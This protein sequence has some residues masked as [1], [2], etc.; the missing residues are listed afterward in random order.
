MSSGSAQA[1]ASAS[2]PDNL[3]LMARL[4]GIV[5]RPRATFEAVAAAPRP[6]APLALLFLVPFAMLAMFFATDVGQ[7][8]LVDQW[9]RTAIAFGQPVDDAQYEEL[10]AWSERGTAY[11][12]LTAL[13]TGPVAAVALATL[14]FTI[15][16]G[17][18]GGAA[19]Y[20]QVLGVTAYAGVI[21]VLRHVIS[22][23]LNYVRETMASPTAL[24]LF[25][26]MVDEASPVARFF[27]IIDVF[28]LWWLVVLAIGSSVIY[29][30]PMRRF[31][32]QLLG[33]YAGIALLLAGAMALLGDS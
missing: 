7:Q 20:G 5:G 29:G 23:P 26:T 4:S 2:S 14:L 6:A 22:G 33:A 17:V 16:T 28:V 25:F 11:A 13:A 18:R 27:G 30:Q 3:S 19:S 31:A 8:A 9:E 21:L 24:V 10:K 1:E 12:A 15:F 32:A